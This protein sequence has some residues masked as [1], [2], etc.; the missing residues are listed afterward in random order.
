[1][2][3]SS[4][5]S[6]VAAIRSFTISRGV[7]YD[8][9]FP[10]TSAA[11]RYPLPATRYPVTLTLLA[12]TRTPLLRSLRPLCTQLATSEHIPRGLATVR[13][14][15][16]THRVI[17]APR[18]SPSFF[19]N[20][21]APLSPFNSCAAAVLH[22]YSAS[23]L[24][25]SPASLT[26]SAISPLSLNQLKVMRVNQLKHNSK[27]HKRK[28]KK[29]HK[30]E[31]KKLAKACN[32]VFNNTITTTLINSK[33]QQLNAKKT[34]DSEAIRK[35]E[36]QNTPVATNENQNTR[37]KTHQLPHS[38]ATRKIAGAIELQTKGTNPVKTTEERK[39]EFDS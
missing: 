29:K 19:A 34:K 18:R 35:E 11:T 24:F 37:G 12:K 15:R 36:R 4:R 5:K 39:G 25:F 27:K 21:A 28:D 20:V 38:L 10:H 30:R 31:D 16:P 1:M 33:N 22:C 13:F 26:S 9:L 14:S 3:Y 7:D 2:E 6:V 8:P 17:T 32:N 23:L